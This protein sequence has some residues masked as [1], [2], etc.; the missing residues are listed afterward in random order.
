M[1][2]SIAPWTGDQKGFRGAFGNHC[3]TLISQLHKILFATSELR[4][5]ATVSMQLGARDEH[6]SAA[7]GDCHFE[8]VVNTKRKDI[9]MLY[10]FNS[11]NRVQIA[12][13][14]VLPAQKASEKPR[15]GTLNSFIRTLSAG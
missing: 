10:V 3:F 4:H 1:Q 11:A 15:S 6:R 13:N 2:L 7:D 12:W 14:N 8:N 5:D 9:A